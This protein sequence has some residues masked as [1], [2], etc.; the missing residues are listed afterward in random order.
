M[1]DDAGAGAEEEVDDA[2]TFV[3]IDASVGER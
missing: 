3:E 1:G 2:V